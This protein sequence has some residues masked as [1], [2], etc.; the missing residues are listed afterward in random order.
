MSS[1][2]K[3]SRMALGELETPEASGSDTEENDTNG[4]PRQEIQVEFEARS[5]EEGDYPGI[6]TLLSQLFIKA[7]TVNV[8]KLS[9]AILGQRCI[10]SVI[11][12]SVEEDEEGC[13]E[14]SEV[15]AV[16]TVVNLSKSE[17]GKESVRGLRS[18]I[19]EQTAKGGDRQVNQYVADILDSQTVGFLINERV[20]NIPAQITVPLWETLMTELRKAKDRSLPFDFSHFIMI[21]KL[22]KTK[23]CEDTQSEAVVFS[24]PEEELIVSESELCID[25]PVPQ[26]DEANSTGSS[27]GNWSD[28]GVEMVPWRRIVLFRAER[29][30]QIITKVKHAFPSGGSM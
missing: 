22:F 1:K 12:Q 24:N 17:E 20:L 7:T 28:G 19:K 16:S 30:E 14:E 23:A 11:K 21:S 9:E 27:T 4:Q 3:V 10:G 6:R 15:Y 8:S 13:E 2:A 5:P 29:L 26:A 25:Y 18:F